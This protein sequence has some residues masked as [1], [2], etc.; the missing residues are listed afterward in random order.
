MA[1]RL[2]L[3]GAVTSLG[4]DLPSFS[5]G[6]VESWARAGR[7]WWE[8][9]VSEFQARHGGGDALEAPPPEVVA[10][11]VPRIGHEPEASIAVEDALAVWMPASKPWGETTE[12]TSRPV[13][14]DDDARFQF[15]LNRSIDAWDLAVNGPGDPFPRPT[16]P[17]LALV[18]PLPP[19]P[20]T[21]LESDA[22]PA[23]E[24]PAR[25][26]AEIE[27]EAELPALADTAET[28][29]SDASTAASRGRKLSE[30]LDRT[31]EAVRAWMAVLAV[32][33]SNR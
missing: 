3:V 17:M 8:T 33:G 14:V 20:D 12:P 15:A 26:D 11:P 21:A 13:A 28:T 6:D 23:A 30:A 1:F 29:D 22:A 19:A 4:V 16:G 32:E 24:E 2:F 31:G 27:A 7:T 10:T 5:M 18:E 9:R 25:E